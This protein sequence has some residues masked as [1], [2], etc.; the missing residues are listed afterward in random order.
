MK[1]LFKISRR[2]VMTAILL[3]AFVLFSNLAV[4]VTVFYV[5]ARQFHSEGMGSGEME[6]IA[7]E[8]REIEAA[9][10]NLYSAGENGRKLQENTNQGLEAV[11]QSRK[12]G[13]VQEEKHTQQTDSS[14]PQ[15]KLL[16][17]EKGLRL[18]EESG[19]LW[20]M[21]IDGEGSVLWEYR[22]PDE[23]PRSYTLVEV[24]SFSRWY[25]KDYPVFVW[26]SAD[27]LMVYGMTKDM[28]RLDFWGNVEQ[29]RMLGNLFL[30][31]LLT[32]LFLIVALALFFGFRFYRALQPVTE[33][34]EKLSLKEKTEIPEKGIAGDLAQQINKT[35]L[36][37]EEQEKKLEKRDRARTDWIA[38][39]SH[40]VRTPLSLIMGWSDELAGRAD[41]DEAWKQKAL[42]I[43][44]QSQV[45]R[46]LI[47]DLNL[48]VK[49]EY[50]YQPLRKERISPAALLR[51]C[52]AEFYNQGLEEGY[53]ISPVIQREA[54]KVQIEA[55]RQLLLRAFRNLIGN[56]IRHNP[57]GCR[58]FVEMSLE[59]EQLLFTFRDDGKGIPSAVID[60]L[61]GRAEETSK[62]HIMGLRIVRQI[63][64]AHGGSLSFGEKMLQGE[65]E[66]VIIRLNAG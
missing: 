18:I 50:G 8:M 44:N 38:G 55:D 23:I 58:I 10:E 30:I 24:A 35:S 66:T 37:L 62:V 49:L 57:Q 53:E 19:C 3:A 21:Y 11:R 27:G 47:A 64:Q 63:V 52:I 31:L 25:L 45:I 13:T 40:D 61:E 51:Q 1:G 17:T 41:G 59:E 43:R 2:Y 7:G 26:K 4:A 60:I 5:S 34:I 15:R 48:T 16:I 33:G 56:S 46:N 20:A 14:Q 65:N 12:E 29:F 28:F 6:E 39:V 36:I 22:L 42:A 32:N 54:E 9:K